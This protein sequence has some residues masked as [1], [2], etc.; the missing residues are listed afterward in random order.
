V[1]LD[2]HAQDTQRF[3]EALTAALAAKT[4]LGLSQK[5]LERA[6]RLLAEAERDFETKSYALDQFIKIGQGH[7]CH[8][9]AVGD[10]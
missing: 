5:A 9:P 7:S 10:Q 8:R 6:Q 4:V 3:L 1:T 2:A